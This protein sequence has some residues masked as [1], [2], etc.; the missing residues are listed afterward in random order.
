QTMKSTG[1]PANV[2]A[3]RKGSQTE[4]QSGVSRAEAAI[5]ESDRNVAVDGLGRRMVSKEPVV[6]ISLVKQRTGQPSNVVVR[7][8]SPVGLALRPQV[9]LATGRLFRPGTSEI[10]VGRAIADGFN[11]VQIGSTIR[12]ARRDWLV[13][14]IFDA[15][16]T[17]FSSE[18]WGDA[19]QM[20]QAFR[21]LNFS[22]VIFRMQTPQAFDELKTR[23][24][25]DQRLTTEF[26]RETQF[27]EDQSHAMSTFVSVLGMVLSAVFS[28]GAIIGAMITRYAAVA[29]RVGE[30]GTLRA[31]G[32]R[33]RSILA[34]FLGESLLLSLLGGVIGLVLASFM[35]LFTVSTMN[36]QT[37]AELAFSFTLTPGIV[38]A[39]LLFALFMGFAGGFLPAVQASLLKIVDALRAG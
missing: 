33:R 31:L 21:R 6:L 32:F 14:G 5:I 29:N 37:F 11:N 9:V 34:A 3:I 8:T 19:E 30:I 10:I 17:G 20:M 13:V 36:F 39:S 7:G 22:A 15:G 2:V 12:F 26:K 25:G 38:I 1:S 4:V 18:V 28:I 23:L 27:Y 16:K 24:E 35:Q